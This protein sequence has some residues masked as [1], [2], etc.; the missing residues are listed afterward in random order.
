M[1]STEMTT[2][3]QS[4]KNRLRDTWIAGDFGQIAKS[5]GA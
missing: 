5:I 4:L 2:E 1:E 3:M